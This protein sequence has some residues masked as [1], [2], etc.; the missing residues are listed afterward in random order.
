MSAGSEPLQ[1][2]RRV[3]DTVVILAKRG[4]W[5][6]SLSRSQCGMFLSVSQ[7]NLAGRVAAVRQLARTVLLKVSEPGGRKMRK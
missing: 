7:T 4:A 6:G 2:D 1:I 5:A 3:H